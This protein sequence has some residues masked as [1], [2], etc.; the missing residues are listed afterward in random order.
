MPASPNMRLYLQPYSFSHD[1]SPVIESMFEAFYSSPD[2]RAYS[3]V[4]WGKRSLAAKSRAEALIKHGLT[5]DSNGRWMIVTDA[6]ADDRIVS[7]AEWQII[8]TCT[9]KD[10]E[11]WKP[12][13]DYFES[14]EECTAASEALYTMTSHVVDA[15][16]NVGGQDG[17]PH[18]RLKLLCTHPDY[19]QKG[20]GKAQVRWGCELADFLGLPA[21]VEA[22]ANGTHLYRS[23]GFEEVALTVS[24]T[25][26]WEIRGS[27]MRRPPKDAAPVAIV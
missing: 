4:L 18:V 15:I 10:L 25:A 24:K 21:W 3:E 26:V 22:S 19:Q 14:S 9:S 27:L 13:V 12:D 20:A 1:L 6:D 7:I 23:C 8:T 17:E 11:P 2:T 16:K 5:S